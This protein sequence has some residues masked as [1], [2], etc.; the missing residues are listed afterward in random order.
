MYRYNRVAR[1]AHLLSFWDVASS[2]SLHD[3]KMLALSLISL[4]PNDCRHREANARVS[5]PRSSHRHT[6]SI[7]APSC[8]LICHPSSSWLSS[9][10][11]LAPRQTAFAQVQTPLSPFP[12]TQAN[13]P[14]VRRLSRLARLFFPFPTPSPAD[15]QYITH[16]PPPPSRFHTALLPLLE[17]TP[18][19]RSSTAVVL[20]HTPRLHCRSFSFSCWI[21][22]TSFSF[23]C[24]ILNTLFACLGFVS[25]R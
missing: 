21:L 2:L 19:P 23:S 17:R 12:P 16:D 15:A 22:K 5:H 13:S 18:E 24:W 8:A 20:T 14:H 7:S 1:A 9:S 6:C 3:T 4:F 10:Q 25:R 11:R